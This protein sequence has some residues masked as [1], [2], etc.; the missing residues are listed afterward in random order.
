MEAPGDKILRYMLTKRSGK[1]NFPDLAPKI[2]YL[3]NHVTIAV[4]ITLSLIFQFESSISHFFFIFKPPNTIT[5]HYF[6]CND[7]FKQLH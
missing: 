4:S 6:C 7:T 1:Y 2:L 3:T 5:N